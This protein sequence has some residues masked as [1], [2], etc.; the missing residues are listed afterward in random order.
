MIKNKKAFL[1]CIATSFFWFS[2]YA[3]VPILSPYA[4]SLGATHKT[5]GIMIGSYGF[6][7]MLLRIPL[8]VISDTIK[9]RK[10]FIIMG[11]CF[12]AVS[13][14]GMWFSKSP[15][16]LILFRSLSGVAATTWVIFT[17]LYT[18]YFDKQDSS[19]AIGILNSYNY[20]GQVTAMF[21]S[22]IITQQFGQNYAFLLAFTGA[23]I[24]LV[25]SFM[26]S[27]NTDIDEAPLRIGELLEV[28]LDY[29]LLVVSFIAVI[30]QVI[31]YSTVYG[32]VPVAAKALGASD[33]QLGMMVTLST[34]PGVF[35][36]ALSG[37]Y[38]TRKLGERNTI[39]IGFIIS[40][41][42]CFL[43]PFINDVD[44]LII[45]QIIGGFGRGLSYPLLMS[46]SIKNIE[47][48][49]RATAMGFFQ[50]IYAIGMFLG[51]VMVGFLSDSVGLNW[52][53]IAAGIISI[54]GALSS[55]LFIR[56]I[57]KTSTVNEQTA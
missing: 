34:L 15:L 21:I 31:T 33:F 36:S 10:V 17:V 13:S 5:I 37:T 16:L 56:T 35:A 3:Y 4:E 9:K 38:F 20:S 52:G 39:V 19:K 27:E 43:I 12:C 11:M 14:L 32:F 44:I 51:P 24:G 28:S 46:L 50:S 2:L 57:K 22:G 53:F 48:R 55:Q 49:K 45:T 29:N 8:G 7:Q 41:F 6:V 40:S 25:L 23:I 18:N 47:Y 54:I 26:I 1:F 42:S 30:S